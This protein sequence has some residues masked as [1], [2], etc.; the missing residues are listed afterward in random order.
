M[1]Q[2]FMRIFIVLCTL[3]IV[4]QCDKDIYIN[5]VTGNDTS[6]DGQLNSGTNALYPVETLQRAI[7]RWGN[8]T[9]VTL[10]IAAGT[11]RLNQLYYTKSTDSMIRWNNEPPV[12]FGDYTGY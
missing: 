12:L 8:E 11:Y 10:H 9:Y 7:S 3:C 6:P 4:I 1:K 5:S 2:S